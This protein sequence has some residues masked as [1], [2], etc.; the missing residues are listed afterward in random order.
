MKKEEFCLN[1]KKTYPDIAPAIIKCINDK[2]L[3]GYTEDQISQLYDL[4]I[5]SHTA[6]FTP[7]SVEIFISLAE[8]N[9]IYKQSDNKTFLVNRCMD[10][11]SVFSVESKGCPECKSKKISCEERNSI[12]QII[13]VKDNCWIC[14]KHDKNNKPFGSSCSKWGEIDNGMR[15]P[16]DVCIKDVC[17]KCACRECCIQEY[18]TKTGNNVDKTVRSEVLELFSDKNRKPIDLTVRKI[19]DNYQSKRLTKKEYTL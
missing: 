4:F 5:M 3:F 19:N 12:D 18:Y 7:K 6:N 10:C 9:G 8:E 13:K 15:K 11:G 1:I 14:E 16:G 2:I 17:N